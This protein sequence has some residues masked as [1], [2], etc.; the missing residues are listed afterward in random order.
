[1]ICEKKNDRAVLRASRGSSTPCFQ[2]KTTS[3][4]MECLLYQI[5]GF[6][7]VGDC[8]EWMNAA[9]RA[10]STKERIQSATIVS[11]TSVSSTCPT[12][13]QVVWTKSRRSALLMGSI[14]ATIAYTTQILDRDLFW[15]ECVRCLGIGSTIAFNPIMDAH[16]GYDHSRGEFRPAMYQADPKPRPVPS[17]DYMKR[18]WDRLLDCLLS[19]SLSSTR[20]LVKRWFTHARPSMFHVCSLP[21]TKHQRQPMHLCVHCLEH[22]LSEEFE[23]S[24]FNEC[25]SCVDQFRRQ[26]KRVVSTSYAVESRSPMQLVA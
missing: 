13:S 6:L 14:R 23:T 19:T 22:K 4:V 16:L 18:Y 26:C 20:S 7:Q 10:T 9:S 17:I 25:S 2:R 5:G 15:R 24:A 12:A 1:M 3:N 11:S 21:Q 8:V